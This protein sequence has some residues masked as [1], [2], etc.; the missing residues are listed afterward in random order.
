MSFDRASENSVRKSDHIRIALHEDVEFHSVTTGFERYRLPY[1]ALPEISRGE[2]DTSTSLFGHW[3]SMPLII[4]SMTGGTQEGRAYNRIFAKAA[5]KFNIA[6]GVGSQRVAIENSDLSDTFR[7][8]DIAPDILLFANLGAVQ[9]NNGCNIESC[10]RAIEMIDADALILH[11]NPLQESIQPGGN[12]NFRGLAEK[13]KCVCENVG[14]PVIVKEVGHGI[15]GRAAKLL[16]DAGVDC[17]DVAGAGGMSWAKVECYRGGLAKSSIS[18]WGTPT[19]DSLMAVRESLPKINIIASGGVR[20]GLDI[21]KSIALGANAAGMALPLLTAASE[22]YDALEELIA[23][24]SEELTTAMFCAGMR[25]IEELKSLPLIE[26]SSIA[27]PC[28]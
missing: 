16:A 12:T 15:S 21:A 3:L 13:I 5:Q 9:L 11:L 1:E 4:S 2:I 24:I 23:Q 8:R 26:T 7:V 27:T 28:I 18:E 6:M 25:T 14:V 20:S 19:V 17:I 10:T 22:S